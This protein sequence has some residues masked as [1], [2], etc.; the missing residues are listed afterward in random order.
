MIAKSTPFIYITKW[1]ITNLQPYIAN[2]NASLIE[3]YNGLD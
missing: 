3:I 1:L 2:L